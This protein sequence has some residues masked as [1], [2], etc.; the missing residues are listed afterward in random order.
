MITFIR[1]ASIAPGK[2]PGAVAFGLEVVKLVKQSHN[3]TLHM[4]RPIAGNPNRLAWTMTLASLAEFETATNAIL[5]DPK[6]QELL[7]TAA[8]L[9]V[10]DTI[11]DEV[12]A[13]F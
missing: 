9:F 12:W 8:E 13:S 3:V 2:A 11:H 4:N 7:A 6:Y 5:V 1:T 10:A